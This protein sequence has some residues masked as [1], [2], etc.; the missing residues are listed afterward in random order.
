MELPFSHALA[1]TIDSTVGLLVGY[2]EDKT[3][4]V[5]VR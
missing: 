1:L 4:S 3:C 2:S 5:L